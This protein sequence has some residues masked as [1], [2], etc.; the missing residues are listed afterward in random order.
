MES[1]DVATVIGD[2]EFDMDNNKETIV[3]KFKNYF[4]NYRCVH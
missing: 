1:K 4:M 3:N 2:A